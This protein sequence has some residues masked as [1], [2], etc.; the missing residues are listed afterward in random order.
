[1][2]RGPRSI[3]QGHEIVLVSGTLDVILEH[4]AKEVGAHRLICNRLE[5]KEGKATGKLLRPVVAGPE[6]ALLIRQHAAE[7]GFD[8]N[9]CNA[10]SDS[11]S[12][13]PML[14]VVGHPCAVNPDKKLK[15]L[16]TAY[17]WPVV[18]LD[19]TDRLS[20]RM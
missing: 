19:G 5:F 7:R 6:K 9:Q 10:Y 4:F 13:V 17:Q 15:R 1:M 3:D 20:R 12:D 16:A 14:S 8:L 11:Y 18:Y 2:A